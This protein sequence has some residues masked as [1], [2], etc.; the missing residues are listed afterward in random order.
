MNNI[1]ITTSRNTKLYIENKENIPLYQNINT[2]PDYINH[3]IINFYKKR[4]LDFQEINRIKSTNYKPQN[5]FKI[6]IK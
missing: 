5:N 1:P 3:T 6:K 4:P 2:N